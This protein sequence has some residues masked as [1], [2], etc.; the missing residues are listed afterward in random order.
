MS[1]K[2]GKVQSWTTWHLWQSS[3]C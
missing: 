3:L 2:K 1:E